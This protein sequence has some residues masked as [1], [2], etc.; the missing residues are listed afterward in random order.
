M[1]RVRP[2]TICNMPGCPVPVE[3]GRCAE[4]AEK[5]WAG[6]TRGKATG[7]TAWKKTR[8][9]VLRRDRN[10]CQLCTDHEGRHL[11][12]GNIVDHIVPVSEGGSD[13]DSNLQTLCDA[14]HRKKTLDEARRA[15]QARR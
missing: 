3:R 5:P 2:L 6:S 10:R 9:R 15:R 13:D 8:A 1:A 4:H 12:P 11:W 7:S 14:C